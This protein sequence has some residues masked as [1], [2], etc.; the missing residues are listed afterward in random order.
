MSQ[1]TH[2]KTIDLMGTKL[3]YLEAG[4]GATVLF[5]HGADGD[6]WSPLLDALSAQHRVITPEHPGFGR[7]PIPAWMMNV[8]DLANFYLDVLQALNLRDVHLVGHC[9]GGWAAAEMAIRNTQRLASLTLLAPAGAESREAS[10]G[11][12]FAW[13]PEE[14]AVRQFH[15]RKLAE[16]WQAAQA[17]LDID[18]VLQN[19]TGLARLAWNPRLHSPQLP[20]WLHRIDVPTLVIWGEDDRVIPLP[21][22]QAFVREI[23]QARFVS[24]PDTGHALPIEGAK[25]IGPQL[26]AFVQGAQG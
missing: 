8:G 6:T 16:A 7:T 2:Y 25:H 21:C 20:F 15:D 22:H 24:L 14:F 4:A 10:I 18:I 26:E 12:V 19:R 1:T 9:V 17:K 11:D 23:K 3:R 5:L 13:G